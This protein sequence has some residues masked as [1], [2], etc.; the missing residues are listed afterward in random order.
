MHRLVYLAGLGLV[1][2]A[3]A[4]LLTDHLTWQPGVT[5]RNGRLVRRGISMA[6][7]QAVLGGPAQL[8]TDLDDL[9]FQ[10]GV[11]VVNEET[12]ATL[13]YLFW[14]GDWFGPQ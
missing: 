6:Q 3:G 9:R 4:F 1:L 13:A 2:L 7:V 11:Q 10:A 14:C 5:E 12:S 8:W